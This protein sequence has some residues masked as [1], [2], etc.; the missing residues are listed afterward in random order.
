MKLHDL[1]SRIERLEHQN[2]NLKPGPHRY[3]DDELDGLIAVLRQS[4]A[5]EPIDP[6]RDAWAGALLAR[7]GL[8]NPEAWA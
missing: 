1:K 6:E 7:E 3:T 2:P 8:T 5:G 4:V